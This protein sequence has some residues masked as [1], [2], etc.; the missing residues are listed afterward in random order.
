MLANLVVELCKLNVLCKLN[1]LCKLNGNFLWPNY[2]L[3]SGGLQ[4]VSPIESH[5]VKFIHVWL[6]GVRKFVLE[7]Y[8]TGFI[9][10]WSIFL[11]LLLVH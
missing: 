7:R 9:E 10:T 3:R 1:E 8:E 11:N 6:P 5:L 2:F 4:S